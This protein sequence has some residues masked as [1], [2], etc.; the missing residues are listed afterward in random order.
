TVRTVERDVSTVTTNPAVAPILDT[1]AGVVSRVS[2]PAA[3][4]LRGLADPSS[5]PVADEPPL[6]RGRPDTAAREPKMSS[7]GLP[8]A[9]LRAAVPWQLRGPDWTPVIPGA[10]VPW[11]PHL[12]AAAASAAAGALTNGGAPGVATGPGTLFQRTR[13]AP[14]SPT[15][16][17]QTDLA[18]LVERPG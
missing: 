16:M 18:S 11:L 17:K 1:T 6:P 9:P 4:E 3:G 12:P 2:E 14:R 8:F 5:G 13:P 10:P 15:S 7:L